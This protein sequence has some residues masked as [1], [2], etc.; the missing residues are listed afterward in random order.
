MDTWYTIVHPDIWEIPL[1]E[2]G[3]GQNQPFLQPSMELPEKEGQEFA[4][5]GSPVP[6]PE[7]S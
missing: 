7:S 1:Q 6:S 4:D 3:R 2:T 5:S